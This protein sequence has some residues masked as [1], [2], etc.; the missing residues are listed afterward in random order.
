[1]KKLKLISL[2]CSLIM[3]LGCFSVFPA[4]AENFDETD[5]RHAG[6]GTVADP[7]QLT[8][9]NFESFV[10]TAKNGTK[11]FEHTSFILMGDIILNDGE[12][13]GDATDWANGA[14]PSYTLDRPLIPYDYWGTFDGNGKTISGIYM[15][16]DSSISRVGLFHGLRAT[17]TSEIGT[18]KNLRLVNSYFESNVTSGENPMGSIAAQ[19]VDRATVKNC[20]SE[21]IL[22]NGSVSKVTSQQWMVA[23]G[24]IVGDALMAAS[25]WDRPTIEDCVFAGSILDSVGAAGGI[26]GRLRGTNWNSIVLANMQIID[27][28]NLGSVNCSL[29]TNNVGAI[30]GGVNYDGSVVRAYLNN[31]MNLNPDVPADVLGN[32]NHNNLRTTNF[33]VVEG[34]RQPDKTIYSNGTTNFT[35]SAYIPVTEISLST[36]L[37]DGLNGWTNKPGYIPN[38]TTFDIPLVKLVNADTFNT[39]VN[40]DTLGLASTGQNTSVRL[41]STNPGLRFETYVSDTGVELLNQLKAAGATYAFNTYITAAKYFTEASYGITELTPEALD[42]GVQAGSRYLVV[43]A[44]DYLRKNGSGD[45]TFAGSVVNIHDNKMEYLARGCV[46]VTLGGVSYD[47]YADWGISEAEAVA[48]VAQKALDDREGTNQVVTDGGETVLSP[49]TQAEYD[50]LEKLVK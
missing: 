25:E 27:C 7:Y 47:I 43:P 19:L 49:Y 39:V 3:V 4:F 45:N 5:Y 50:C 17:S 44:A 1:M 11:T 46:T 23:I 2:L 37:K 29:T 28:I 18:V 42:N 24:G 48:T 33:I 12:N 15:V 35:T 6:S 30:V 13:D 34:L 14:R 22:T 31:C 16:A 38:P 21:A 41:S 10:N 32:A 20:Y 26:V 9:K 40:A 8:N 36:F